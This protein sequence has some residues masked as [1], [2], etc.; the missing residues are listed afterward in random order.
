[1]K[2]IVLNFGLR[3]DRADGVKISLPVIDIKYLEVESEPLEPCQ[4]GF[5]VF[6]IALSYFL[7]GNDAPV[8][9]FYNQH[10]SVR[11]A[12]EDFIQMTLR[13]GFLLMQ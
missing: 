5:R 9:I 6:F 7:R 1:M 4:Q 3:I 10:T 8:F 2:I 11:A 12:R 13:N